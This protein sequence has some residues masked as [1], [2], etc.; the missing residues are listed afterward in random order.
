M[1][2]LK[3]LVTLLALFGAPL[4]ADAEELR[5]SFGNIPDLYIRL[6]D[7]GSVRIGIAPG[8]G[9]KGSLSETEAGMVVVEHD[10]DGLPITFTTILP[11]LTAVHSRHVVDGGILPSQG[12][13]HCEALSTLRPASD[14]GSV[15][16]R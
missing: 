4:S 14:S 7:G 10:R 15:P 8:I 16:V 6:G 1:P 12:S 9:N 5:C 11:D 2:R 3:T 13:G